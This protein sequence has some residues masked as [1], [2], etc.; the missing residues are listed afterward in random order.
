MEELIQIRAASKHNV[1]TS[2]LLGFFGLMASAMIAAWL[3][4]QFYLIAIFLTG[5]SS[6]ALVIGWF[7]FREPLHSVELSRSNIRYVHR[8][9]QWQVA[10][11]NIQRI[12]VPKVQKGLE[13]KELGMVGIK[14]KD[15]APLLAD[16]SPRLMSN[17]LMEQRPLLLHSTGME[18]ISDSSYGDSMLEHDR[19]KTQDGKV[20]HGIQ[21]MFANR[22]DKLRQSLGY[23]L[24]ISVAELDR[25]EQEFV[26]LLKQCQAKVIKY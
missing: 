20:L 25:S 7:K 4:E 13:H 18:R 8:H 22:M 10:W 12:D 17:I 1:L 26:I 3:P 24:F 15:Y 19:Y 9:G 6:V 14:I 5:A 16:I 11:D 21:A 2:I 23:D